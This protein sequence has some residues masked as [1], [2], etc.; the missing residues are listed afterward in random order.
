MLLSGVARS[1]SYADRSWMESLSGFCRWL[2]VGDGISSSR[3][4][5]ELS[6]QSASCRLVS[7]GEGMMA[8]EVA[9]DVVLVDGPV[10][11]EVGNPG[12]GT[13]VVRSVGWRFVG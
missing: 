12:V 10:G 5:M 9:G 2:M 7:G 3:R 6:M 8:G 11:G 13:V 1:V 4:V